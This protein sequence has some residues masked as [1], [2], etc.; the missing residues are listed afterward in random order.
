MRRIL[1]FAFISVVVILA[2][3]C[4]KDDKT[5][6]PGAPTSAFSVQIDGAEWKP[7]ILSA[8]YSTTQDMVMIRASDA[9]L[10]MITITFYGHTSRTYPVDN[11]EKSTVCGY[12]LGTSNSYSTVFLDEPEGSVSIS[13]LDLTNCIVS[14]T[15]SFVLNDNEGNSLTLSEGKFTNVPVQKL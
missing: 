15:F 1:F 9:S 8:S 3:G 11:S 10:K 12:S 4:G 5:E 14:G 13:E 2:T 6:V 7:N